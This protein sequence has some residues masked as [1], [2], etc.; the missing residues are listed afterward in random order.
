MQRTRHRVVAGARR[1]R[2]CDSISSTQ[3]LVMSGRQ[4]TVAD[5]RKVLPRKSTRLSFRRTGWQFGGLQPNGAE[6]HTM[7]K[8]KSF[9]QSVVTLS[10]CCSCGKELDSS[11][12]QGEALH[13]NVTTGRPKE[14]GP[15]K[16]IIQPNPHPPEFLDFFLRRR[17]K[18]IGPPEEENEKP[19]NSG[20][21]GLGRKL[22]K[23]R[24]AYFLGTNGST[25]DGRSCH[26][27]CT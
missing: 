7:R 1:E 8:K 13:R 16:F 27:T 24:G 11:P 17:T 10:L 22:S 4:M 26:S 9:L 19:K 6:G 20:W 2:G 23:N 5:S 18:K 25:V 15:P 12:R 14:I 21:W 3:S